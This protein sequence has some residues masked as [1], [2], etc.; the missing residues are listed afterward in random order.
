MPTETYVGAGESVSGLTLNG[1]DVL[2]MSGASG[3]A[4]APASAYHTIVNAGGQI[5]GSDVSLHDTT[6]N[7]GGTV[8]LSGRESHATDTVVSGNLTVENG[9]YFQLSNTVIQDGGTVTANSGQFNG[10]YINHGG[11]LILGPDSDFQSTSQTSVMDGGTLKIETAY[12]SSE[13]TYLMTGGKIDLTALNYHSDMS[14]TFDAATDTVTLDHSNSYAI[15]L[16]GDYD[17]NGFSIARDDAGGTVLTARSLS[18]PPPLCFLRGTSILTPHGE[19]PIELLA[20]GDEIVTARGR[21]RQIK[22]IGSATFIVSDADPIILVKQGAL[23]GGLPHKDLYLTS[24]HA[25]MLG[26]IL[27]PV[28]KLAN[29]V[30]IVTAGLAIATVF[31]VELASHDVIVANGAPAESFRDDGN[32]QRFTASAGQG[33]EARSTPTCLAVVTAGPI[34]D[35]TRRRLDEWARERVRVAGRQESQSPTVLGRELVNSSIS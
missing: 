30:S 1:G 4:S 9:L 15:S 20:V 3:L 17:P 22:W 5:Q 21:R 13:Q 26:Q 23:P 25:L 19:K 2:T 33:A 28:G 34:L 8:V 31:H 14:I 12:V 18:A 11:T 16:V 24:G 29:G 10:V 7:A 32:R 35:R 6:I 27:V